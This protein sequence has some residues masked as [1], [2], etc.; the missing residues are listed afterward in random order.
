MK[1]F[2]FVQDFFGIGIKKVA[3]KLEKYAPSWIQFTKNRKEA[4]L[5]FIHSIGLCEFSSMIPGQ[6][7]VVLQYCYKTAGGS[8]EEWNEIWKNAVQVISY[9]DLKNEFLFPVNFTHV[10]LGADATEFFKI[11]P[12]Y[13]TKKV[14][15]TG[16]IAETESLDVL[17][18]A[19]KLTDTTMYHTGENFG[20]KT[21]YKFLPYLSLENLNILLNDVEYVSCLRK[22]EGFEL[23]GI[24]GLFAGARP[25]VLDIES[26]NWYRNFGY[27]V[28]EEHLLEDLVKVLSQPARS[29]SDEE[30]NFLYKKFSWEV[31]C[32]KIYEDLKSF[33][34]KS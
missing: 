31:I 18:E 16:H 13:R 3:E 27:T 19:C 5:V 17:W 11:F 23:L 10:P 6:D 25:I 26:Y 14:F 15:A 33:R 20:Y 1:V 12:E 21:N 24:E 34:G 29:V 28:R 32:N 9:Y 2:N 4:D 7:Y 8:K 22:V 30:L